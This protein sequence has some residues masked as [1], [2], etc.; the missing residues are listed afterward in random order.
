MS[1]AADRRAVPVYLLIAWTASFL[2]CLPI[3]RAA[4]TNAAN[5]AYT[6]GLMWCPAL[7]ALLT[8]A[9][10]GRPIASLGWSRRQ[11]RYPNVAPGPGAPAPPHRERTA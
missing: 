5:G 1:P 7:G 6:T 11:T 4:G 2:F 3:I 10:L 9:Y 8:C